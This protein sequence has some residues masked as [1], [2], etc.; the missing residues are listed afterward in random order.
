MGIIIYIIRL[1]LLCAPPS[2]G[3][4]KAILSLLDKENKQNPQDLAD[5]LAPFQ[6]S[7]DTPDHCGNTPLLLAIKLGYVELA[8]LLIAEGFKCDITSKLQLVRQSSSAEKSS[9]S[10]W[11]LREGPVYHLLDEC[12]LL[13]SEPLI[14]AVYRQLQR[15]TYNLWMERKQTVLDTLMNIPDFYVEL[16]WEFM[17]SG[18]WWYFGLV[19]SVSV[20][21]LSLA[22]LLTPQHVMLIIP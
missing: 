22:T 19:M 3:D 20:Q 1:L 6:H 13:R 4:V 12:V 14:E 21:I 10:A 18:T 8:K 16:N 2:P 9:T 7:M 5:P 11:H 17:G 15:N